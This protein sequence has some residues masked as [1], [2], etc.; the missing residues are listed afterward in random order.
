MFP[1]VI[2]VALS[3]QRISITL[4]P[5][6]NVTSEAY[7]VFGAGLLLCNETW[8]LCLWVHGRGGNRGRM[9]RKWSAINDLPAFKLTGSMCF[10]SSDAG[11]NCV[12]PVILDRSRTP[13]RL[14]SPDDLRRFA[15]FFNT[16]CRK[17]GETRETGVHLLQEYC[18]GARKFPL[19]D[20]RRTA[21]S[22]A[23]S[24]LH[25]FAL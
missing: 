4:S 20:Q 7:Q 22:G 18:S 3:T 24:L 25:T 9:E 8:A 2:R 21:G 10:H 11:E 12:L 23:T 14:S 13:S 15:S 16:T 17:N 6:Q 5:Q 19:N 1:F